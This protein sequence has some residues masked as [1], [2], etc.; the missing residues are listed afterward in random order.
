MQ[1]GER[2]LA[3]A[4][5]AILGVALLLRV[6][7]V[8][9]Q[10]GDVLFDYPVVDEETYVALARRLADGQEPTPGAWF[11][12]PGLVYALGAVFWVAGPGLLV[13]RLVQ[14]VVSTASCGLAFAIAR[15]LFSTRVALGT[16]AILAVHGVLVFETYELLPPTWML[17]TDL[18]ALGALL[19]AKGRGTPAA[20]LGAGAALGVAGLFGPTVLPFGLVGVGV[21]RRPALAG[22]F[23]LGTALA[24]APVTWGNWQR[25]HELVLVSTNG[26]V[27]LYIGNNARYAETLAVRPGPHWDALKGHAASW[28]LHEAAAFWR[29][30][31]GRAVALTARKLYLFFDGPEIPRDTDL[32]A[33]REGSALLRWLVVP[34]PPWLPDGLLVPLALVGAAASLRDGR[35]LVV[36]YAFLATQALV[37]AAFFVTSRYRVPALPVFA[38]F[39]AAGVA[40][41]ASMEARARALAAGGFAVLAL[42]LNVPTAESTVSYAAELDFYRGLECRLY[43]HDLAR[44][45]EYF[46]KAARTDPRDGR[47]WFELGNTADALG[48]KDEAIDAWGRAGDADPWDER[49]RRKLAQGLERR[50]DL[51][52]AIAALQAD[53]DARAHPEPGFY[54][55]DHLDL[56]LLCARRGLAARAAGELRA[57]READPRRFVLTVGSFTQAALAKVDVPADAFWSALATADDEAGAHELAAEVRVRL[58]AL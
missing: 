40:A 2:R 44:A 6:A 47:I 41:M 15:R 5:A 16:A 11:H 9:G 13:P 24:I 18:L 45:A 14:A 1:R 49:A 42:A 53:V 10:R 43:L 57:A 32:D 22:A 20:A 35:R 8:L 37:V 36:P 52:G 54:A 48:R 12:P 46:R 21:L 27:N 26:A 38:M 56:A 29:E 7:Y 55:S 17:A 58:G 3:T 33:M 4:L 31:P 19:R 23:A 30:Q 50:G 39:A 51:D 28:F 25:G 34:G